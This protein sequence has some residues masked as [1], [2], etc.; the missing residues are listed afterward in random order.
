MS[1]TWAAHAGLQTCPSLHA[2]L[3]RGDRDTGSLLTVGSTA[4]VPLAAA[5]T[6]GAALHPHPRLP[7]PAVPLCLLV[8]SDP[9]ALPVGRGGSRSPVRLSHAPRLPSQPSARRKGGEG[10][11][12][13]WIYRAGKPRRAKSKLVGKSEVACAECVL[14][15]S[16]YPAL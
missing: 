7:V 10:G 4:P 6:C 15:L 14:S 11:T 8:P 9:S 12:W 3:V 5:G 2:A 1:R 16:N 13:G